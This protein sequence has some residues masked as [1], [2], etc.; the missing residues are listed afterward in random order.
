MNTFTDNVYRTRR[1]ELEA[2]HRGGAGGIE[3][4]LRHSL[5]VDQLVKSVLDAASGA[6]PPLAVVA[7][8]GYGRQELCFGSDVDL[9]LLVRRL[10]DRSTAL[11]KDVFYGLLG[12]GLAVSHAV[13]TTSDCIK[14]APD[15]ETITALLDGRFIA[16]DLSL[17]RDLERRLRDWVARHGPQVRQ[18]IA[19]SFAVRHGK[20]RSATYLFEPHVK[21]GVGGLR[22]AQALVWA[23]RAAGLSPGGMGDLAGLGAVDAEE[24]ELLKTSVDFLLRV[25]NHLHV[26]SGKKNDR[27]L[28]AGQREVAAFFG[29][30][31]EG[32][33]P[34]EAFM[35]LYQKRAS[36]LAYLAR[37]ILRRLG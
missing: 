18:Q 32:P 4:C 23:A 17:F 22:D 20:Y 11:S 37:L 1:E 15:T 30:G 8:G 16:G 2:V 26:S 13:R 31:G 25:R 3:I 6:A 28:F 12:L 7:V 34:V 21:E 5:L 27:L 9:L 10:D 14:M 24:A 35:R 19:E 33:E 36:E 29:L